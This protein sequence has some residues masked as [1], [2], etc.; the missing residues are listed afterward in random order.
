MLLRT[1]EDQKTRIAPKLARIQSRKRLLFGTSVYNRSMNRLLRCA[2]ALGVFSS[3]LADISV[4][5]FDDLVVPG[6][7]GMASESRYIFTGARFDFPLTI[8]NVDNGAPTWYTQYFLPGGGSGK[9]ALV[10]GSENSTNGIT[11]TIPGTTQR[12]VIQGFYLDAFDT[13]VGSS[14][15]TLKTFDANGMSL[16]TYTDPT[17]VSNHRRLQA[18][19][20]GIHRIE[21]EVDAD[22][23]LFDNF[24]FPRPTGL[25]TGQARL[26][27]DIIVPGGLLEAELW[28]GE[29]RVWSGPTFS[30]KEILFTVSPEAPFNDYTLKIRS[31]KSLW[32]AVPITYS[33]EPIFDL[34]VTLVNG[35]CNQDNYI[36][37]DDYLILNDSFDLDEDDPQFDPRADLDMDDYVGTDDYLIISRNFD[38]SGD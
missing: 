34:G 7:T 29:S 21:V 10:L 20:N 32:M 16:G 33:P 8:Y 15:G 13:E 30:H 5:N 11:F 31:P 38:R 2:V 35:D 36:G 9:N 26:D 24:S 27:G 23:G 37:T 28:S 1:N 14:I 6:T 18:S 12:G 22:G 17:P 3:A 25:I 19:T 4:I